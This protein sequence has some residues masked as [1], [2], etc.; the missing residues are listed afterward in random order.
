MIGIL[1]KREF[2]RKMHMPG[3]HQVK[4]KAEIRVMQQEPRNAKECQQTTKRR[5]EWN[6]VAFTA[7]RKK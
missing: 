3:E 7:L 4:R 6:R 1:T 5:E 2:W